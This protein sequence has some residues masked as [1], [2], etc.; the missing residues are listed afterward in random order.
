MATQEDKDRKPSAAP[1]STGSSAKE[2]GPKPIEGKD[3]DVYDPVGMARK[4]AGIVKEI[5]DQLKQ[6]GTDKDQ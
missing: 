3:P 6:E 5:E 1:T 2:T 4:K